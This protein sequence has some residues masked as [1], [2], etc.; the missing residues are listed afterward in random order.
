LS[1][2][3]GIGAPRCNHGWLSGQQKRASNDAIFILAW[4]PNNQ[5]NFVVFSSES[6][7]LVCTAKNFGVGVSEK[8]N[9]LR[10]LF[11]LR[12]GKLRFFK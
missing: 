3:G 9:H 8:V 7:F 6:S 4:F 12:K 2:F 1:N 5:L 10:V 11:V